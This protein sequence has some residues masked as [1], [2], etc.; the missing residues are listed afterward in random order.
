[1]KGKW[2]KLL[3]KWSSFHQFGDKTACFVLLG[4]GPEILEAI[5]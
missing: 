3:K 4:N 1:M 2:K 5:V